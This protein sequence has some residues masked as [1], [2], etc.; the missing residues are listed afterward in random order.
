MPGDRGLSDRAAGAFPQEGE[1]L[2]L[3]EVVEHVVAV[4][5]RAMVAGRELGVA[6]DR[7]ESVSDACGH[8]G[9]EPDATVG[10][11][12]FGGERAT[13]LLLEHVEDGLQRHDGALAQRFEPFVDPA[14]RGAE[15]DAELAD[16]ALG[17]ELLELL[18]ERVVA[19]RLD[20][21]VVELVEVDVVG[22]E[23]PQ[24][25]FELRDAPTPAP[26]RAVAPTGPGTCA[27]R[28]CRSRTWW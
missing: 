9:D 19:D 6:G 13:R 27:R 28:R 7:P 14:D 5:V 3:V 21:R 11:R 4:A 16:L 26:S 1:R 2:G 22:A 10:D 8:A 25:R 15:R 18:P 24:R 20:A 12:R 17:P 23:P